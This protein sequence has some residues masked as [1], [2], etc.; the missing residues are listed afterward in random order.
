MSELGRVHLSQLCSLTIE[1]VNHILTTNQI[2]PDIPIFLLSD[3]QQPE[4]DTLL[5][6][7]PN[8]HTLPVSAEYADLL[9][10]MEMYIAS[11]SFVFI[12]NPYSTLSSNIASIR[13]SRGYSHESNLFHEDQDLYFETF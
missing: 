8:I 2:S 5:L 9:L 12:G 3:N 1:T 13:E 6:N 11:R 7:N 10:F 4:M